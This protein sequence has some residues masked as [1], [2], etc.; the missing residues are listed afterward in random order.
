MTRYLFG[1]EP[2]PEPVLIP[3]NGDRN[4]VMNKVPTIPF[5]V[6]TGHWI[7]KWLDISIEGPLNEF[8]VNWNYTDQF[9]GIS[10]VKIITLN[11]PLLAE[12]ITYPI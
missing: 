12:V 4:E 7:R 5:L 11:N 2:F 3:Y 1:A 10:I 8:S 9:H 6:M